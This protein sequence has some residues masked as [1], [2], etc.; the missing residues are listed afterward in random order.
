VGL[1]VTFFVA[2]L[3]ALRTYR[4]ILETLDDLKARLQTLSLGN[5]NTRFSLMHPNSYIETDELID[6]FYHMSAALEKQERAKLEELR[7]FAVVFNKCAEPIFVTEA[8]PQRKRLGV[9]T[10]VNESACQIYRQSRDSLIGQPL[11]SVIS[12]LSSPEYSAEIVQLFQNS[13]HTFEATVPEI[14]R[15]VI[16][17]RIYHY[18]GKTRALLS[19]PVATSSTPL[20]PTST[21]SQAKNEFISVMSHEIRTPIG[22]IIGF[23]EILDIETENPEHKE[24]LASILENGKNLVRLIDDILAYGKLSSGHLNIAPSPTQTQK[25]FNELNNYGILKVSRSSKSLQFASRFDDN[26]PETIIIDPGRL[27]QIVTN[28]INNAVKY[29]T[30]GT[31]TLGFELKSPRGRHP[32]LSVSLQD[33]GQ[34]ISE[35]HI[36]HI[37]QPFEQLGVKNS[38]DGSVGLGLSI[39]KRLVELMG[40]SIH[41]KSTEGVGSVFTV[42]LDI[43]TLSSED[44]KNG[45]PILSELIAGRTTLKVICAEDNNTNRAIISILLSKMGINCIIVKSGEEL[46]ER[47]KRERFDILFLDLNMSKIS[48]IEACEKIR[49]GQAGQFN[50]RIFITALTASVGEEIQRQCYTAGMDHFL[51]KPFTKHTLA[52]TFR[53]YDETQQKHLLRETNPKSARQ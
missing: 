42:E 15:V 13:Q 28:L 8:D 34:G 37:W 14:G 31:I 51:S 33:E 7:E 12:Q 41:C 36:E 53:R 17:A 3:V 50:K 2:N 38:G 29:S 20:P 11:S 23:S 9:V 21:A 44:Q 4:R 6:T 46:L 1:S 16:D 39:S 52:D 30:E 40:G 10:Q 43:T 32:F 25:L 5:F 19:A 45:V 27:Y 48:G 47:L 26:L 22:A 18:K 24:Y 35:E 49:A